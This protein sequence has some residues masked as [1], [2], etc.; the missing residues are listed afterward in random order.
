MNFLGSAS[1]RLG[2]VATLVCVSSDPA[3]AGAFSTK[4]EDRPRQVEIGGILSQPG[5]ATAPC[6][7]GGQGRLSEPVAAPA[8]AQAHRAKVMDELSA[9]A[10][11]ELMRLMRRFEVATDSNKPPQDAE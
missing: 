2:V 8:F 7:S 9:R 11:S 10:L 5:V 1:I 4:H 6:A 3:I